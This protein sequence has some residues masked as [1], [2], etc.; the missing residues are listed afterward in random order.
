[1]S[2]EIYKQVAKIEI[3]SFHNFETNSGRKLKKRK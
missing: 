1:M 3:I 2:Y